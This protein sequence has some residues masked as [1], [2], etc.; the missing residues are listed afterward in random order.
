VSD[1]LMTMRELT[2]FLCCT[3]QTIYNYMDRGMP[4]IQKDSKNAI[5][6]EK[7]KVMEWLEE[8]QV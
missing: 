8:G 2:E 3:R 7:E 5:R 6:F 4:K 1:K